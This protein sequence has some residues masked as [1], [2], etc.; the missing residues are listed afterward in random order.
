MD[1][2]IDLAQEV[3]VR[4]MTLKAEAV[5]Q[6]L[7][8]HPPFAHHGASPDSPRKVNQQRVTANDFF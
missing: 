5:E 6:R 4:N 8:H 3:I 1:E 7:L 2:A